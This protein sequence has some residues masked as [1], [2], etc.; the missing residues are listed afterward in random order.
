MRMPISRVRRVA[1]YATRPYNPTI[2]SQSPETHA[3]TIDD[4]IETLIARI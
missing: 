3:P 1:A 4:H 2:D